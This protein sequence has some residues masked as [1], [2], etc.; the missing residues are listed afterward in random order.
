MG[1]VDTSNR[2][3][4]ENLR[5]G[6]SFVFPKGLIHFLYNVDSTI[7]ALAISGLSSQSPGAQIGSTASFTSK[8]NIPDYILKKAYQIDGQNVARI[9]RGLGGG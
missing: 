8:P 1:F 4:T 6:D 5:P 7:P 3:F 9:R 2:L